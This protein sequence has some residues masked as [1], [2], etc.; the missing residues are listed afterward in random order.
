MV[1]DVQHREST[2][3]QGRRALTDISTLEARG[4]DV[5]HDAPPPPPPSDPVV[6]ADANLE[7]AVHARLGIPTGEPVRQTDMLGLTNLSAVSAGITSLGGLEYAT[8]LQWLDLSANTITSV[9]PFGSLTNLT[10]LT[11][12]NNSITGH[13]SAGGPDRLDLARAVRQ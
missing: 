3:A 9:T 1:D 7:A 5:R 2:S 11:L 12:G 4:V 6:F 13:H 8:N 10:G